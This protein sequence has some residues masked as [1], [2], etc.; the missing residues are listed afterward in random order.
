MKMAGH[1]TQ[2]GTGSAYHYLHLTS[3][4]LKQLPPDQVLQA[5]LEGR[6]LLQLLTGILAS[7]D[8]DLT[9]RLVAM[10]LI[11]T[12]AVN[13]AAGRL[14]DEKTPAVNDIKAVR[15]RLGIS[16]AQ[17]RGAYYDEPEQ[18]GGVHIIVRQFPHRRRKQEQADVWN[19]AH[20]DHPSA[21]D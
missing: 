1:D 19:S 3:E 18:L 13:E 2:P 15:E 17:I 20:D 5:C 10:D 14:P 4:E 8:K 9:L 11:Y 12:Q 16:P 21:M 7:P 6:R